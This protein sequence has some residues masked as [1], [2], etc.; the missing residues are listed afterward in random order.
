[1]SELINFFKLDAAFDP[2]TSTTHEIV[3]SSDPAQFRRQLTVVK[4]WTRLAELD[5]GTFGTVWLEHD[6]KSKESRAVKQ[7]SKS[8][9]SNPFVGTPK[10]ELLALSKLSK[11]STGN[12]STCLWRT[13]PFIAPRSLCAFSWVV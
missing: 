6:E 9:P 4:K 2:V 8:T 12:N 3:Q 13:D 10:R 5:R 11:V 7:I 1:M